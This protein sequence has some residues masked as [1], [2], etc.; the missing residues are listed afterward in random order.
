MNFPVIFTAAD[1]STTQRSNWIEIPPQTKTIAIHIGC[2]ATGSPLGTVTLEVS[3]HGGN[4]TA[5][6]PYAPA[7]TSSPAGGA[8]TAIYD[9]IS[10]SA[11]YIAVVYTASSGGTGA[12]WTNDSGASG[13]TPFICCKE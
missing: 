6:Q 12:S 2:T 1:L 8:F 7:P 4:G 13:T 11:R 5:G 10:T 3:G 9:L